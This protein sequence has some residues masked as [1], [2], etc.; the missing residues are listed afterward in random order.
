MLIK[1]V[2]NIGPLE[3]ILNTPSHHRVHHGKSV[4][5]SCLR[6]WHVRERIRTEFLE[7]F[8]FWEK[9]AEYLGLLIL[10]Y[11]V[12]IPRRRLKFFTNSFGF[13]K[14]RIQ[15]D[16]VL[17]SKIFNKILKHEIDIA[18]IKIMQVYS[19]FGID[20]LVLFF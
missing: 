19:L 11:S 15:L 7:K 9:F 8:N 12:K 4:V 3:L 18:L 6:I 20:Y 5:Q 13:V 17:D 14:I 1:I 10:Y 16:I 2:D